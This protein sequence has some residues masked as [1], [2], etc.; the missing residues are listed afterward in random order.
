MFRLLIVV[1]V[2]ALTAVCLSR[3]SAQPPAPP[4]GAA[5]TAAADLLG[6]AVAIT[7]KSDPTYGVYLRDTQITELG[8]TAFLVGVGVDSG[9]GE[10][11]AG[12]RSWIAVDDISEIIEFESEDDLRKTLEPPDERPEA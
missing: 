5:M 8:G 4:G 10:W 2:T 7:L 9:A 3:L 12:R 1:A 6:K 11:T